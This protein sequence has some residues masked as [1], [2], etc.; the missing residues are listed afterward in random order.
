M[1][2]GFEAALLKI[3]APRLQPLGYAYDAR[4]RLGH[5]LS[6]FTKPLADNAQAVIQFQRQDR[7][8][9]D[10]FT[11][12]L[13]CARSVALS[14]ARTRA[15]RL[16]YVLWYVH[17]LRVYPAPDFWWTAADAAQREAALI[18]AADQIERYGVPWVEDPA[19]PRPWEMPVHRTGEFCAAVRAVL[20]PALEDLGY[21]MAQQSLPGDLPYCYF[22]KRRPDGS[23]ALIEPQAIYSLSPGEFNFDVR[24]QRRADGDPLAFN[25]NYGHGRSISLAQLVWQT[26]DGAPLDRLSI[27]E[28]QSLFWH[29]RDRAEL[30]AQLREALD[31]IA[32]IGR[33][34][35]EHSADFNGDTI[36]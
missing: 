33:A 35:V 19:A 7:S 34:W 36:T 17:D 16:G 1:S 29:Y 9:P 30:D 23:F 27:G 6:G 26:R 28:V 11:V 24:L 21:R 25:G 2:S 22:V 13:I 12:N 4:R 18:D 31:Q 14:A 3:I 10:R 5:E 20:G 32:H 8:A 15:A